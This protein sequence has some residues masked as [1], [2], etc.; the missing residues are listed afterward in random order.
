MSSLLEKIVESIRL[1]ELGTDDFFDAIIA[2]YAY[3]GLD[4]DSILNEINKKISADPAKAK[5]LLILTAVGLYRG[6]KI[7]KISKTMTVAKGNELKAMAKGF[8]IKESIGQDKRLTLTLSRLAIVLPNVGAKCLNYEQLT[9]PAS[10]AHLVQV[11]KAPNQTFV[12]SFPAILRGT[13]IA[14]LIPGK[15]YNGITDEAIN[16]VLVCITGYAFVESMVLQ[17]KKKDRKTGLDLYNEVIGYVRTAWNSPH[18]TSDQRKNFFSFNDLANVLGGQ[19]YAA[20][21]T[22]YETLS[23]SKLNFL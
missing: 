15:S 16:A 20:I 14:S 8:N 4:I 12:E 9:R 19:W 7:D 22:H 6:N 2:D 13:F 17:Q 11:F 5:H 10:N 18:T 3:Q 1:D 21:A 23:N